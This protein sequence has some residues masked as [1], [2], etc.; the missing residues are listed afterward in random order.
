[1]KS[2]QAVIGLRWWLVSTA[3][4]VL[5]GCAT[6]PSPK[7]GEG[8]NT[9]TAT[10]AV[11]EVSPIDPWENW[12]RKVYGFN[13]A[14]DSA[15]LKP[16]AETYQKVVP[17][18]VRSGVSNVLGN[19]KDVWSAANHVLQGKFMVGMEM[20]MRVLVNTSFGLGGL[21]DPATEMRLEKRPTDFGLTL[22]KWGL[23]NG[24]YMMLPLLGPSTLR[25]SAG[26]LVDRNFGAS[27]LPPTTGGQVAVTTVEVVS[28]RAGFLSA[29]QMLD[30]VA[31][32][33]YSFLRDAYLS[34]RR[35]ALYDGAPPL[36]NFDD[37][38][39]DAAKATKPPAAGTSV[40]KPATPPAGLSK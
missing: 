30:Q 6:A 32:D 22:G 13:D 10:N 39:E 18:L 36:E 28:A 3:M 15:V 33:K 12:N 40:P 9:N 37:E 24:P 23:G 4:L 26:Y 14:V 5:S 27:K 16:V 2:V 8:T 17:S 21:L 35:D 34:R 1:M 25:D 38:P 7:T 20:G 19:I 31:L 29:G 11:A